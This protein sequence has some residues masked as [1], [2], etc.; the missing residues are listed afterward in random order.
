MN[1]HVIFRKIILA[2]VTD[3]AAIAIVTSRTR[4]AP[5]ARY[6]GPAGVFTSLKLNNYPLSETCK[7]RSVR[8]PKQRLLRKPNSVYYKKAEIIGLIL[9]IQKSEQKKSGKFVRQETPD[10]YHIEIVKFQIYYV[11]FDSFSLLLE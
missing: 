4:T 7:L 2:H 1:K 10:R 9:G 6:K 11:V 5:S 8:K 3:Y